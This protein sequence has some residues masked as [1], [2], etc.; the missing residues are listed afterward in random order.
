MVLMMCLR[1]IPTLWIIGRRSYNLGGLKPWYHIL[2]TFSGSEDALMRRVVLC[3]IGC[4]VSGQFLVWRI[5]QWN[6]D[7]LHVVCGDE[8]H[9]SI[10]LR[11][12]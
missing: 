1:G 11:C 6:H 4:V 7:I 10:A 3:S 8:D 2:V 5:I 9:H 12:W